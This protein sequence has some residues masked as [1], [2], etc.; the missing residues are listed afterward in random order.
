MMVDYRKLLV[1]ACIVLQILD[2]SFTAYG[3]TFSSLGLNIEGNP[4]VKYVMTLCGIVPGLFLVKSF[5]IAL[6]HLMNRGN[7]PTYFFAI[8]FGIYSWVIYLWID[9]TFVDNLIT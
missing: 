5:G 9:A 4:M 7:A 2:G 6:I 3:A 8:I 1:L